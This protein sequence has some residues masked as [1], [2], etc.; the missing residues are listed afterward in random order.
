[1]SKLAEIDRAIAACNFILPDFQKE[2]DELSKRLELTEDQKI[3]IGKMTQ[4]I[5]S[6][7]MLCVEYKNDA[8]KNLGRIPVNA[9][10]LEC[11]VLGSLMVESGDYKKFNDI[12]TFLKPRH[13]YQ[14]RHELIY[15]AILSLNSRNEPFDLTSVVNELRRLGT[16]EKVGGAQYIAE[17]AMPI[18]QAYKADLHSK[19]LV[20]M[21]VKREFTMIGSDLIVS[22]YSDTVD[23]FE[24]ADEAVIKVNE[25][26][27]WLP[28]K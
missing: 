12:S 9:P 18:T 7:R 22:G 14:E 5:K 28:K 11:N 16:L 24:L 1:M 23:C 6:V 19:I 13:F 20:E 26:R 27:S 2:I 10:E 17:L 4:L 21:A 15:S 8:R 25:V 3:K